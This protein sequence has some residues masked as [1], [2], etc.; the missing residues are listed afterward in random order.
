MDETNWSGDFYSLVFSSGFDSRLNT[1]KVFLVKVHHVV[2]LPHSDNFI[3][4]C[5]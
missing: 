4:S 2:A 3:L 5:N 1:R